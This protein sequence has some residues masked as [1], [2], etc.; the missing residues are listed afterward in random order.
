MGE[1]FAI[2]FDIAVVLILIISAFVGFRRG[3][4]RVV[5]GLVSTAL[6]FGVALLLS[7]PI[8]DGI[9]G[10]FV[11]KPIEEQFDNQT[12]A[13]LGSLDLGNIVNM[14][15][16]KVVINGTSVGD[17]EV[18]YAGTRKTVID[19]SKLDLSQTGLTS[20][21]LLKIGITED[22]LSNLNAKTAD[23]TM[24]DITN[25]GLGKLA[26]AQYLAVNLVS[27]PMFSGFDSIIDTVNSYF[28]NIFGTSRNGNA[29]VTAIRAITLQM[30]EMKEG[31]KAAVM[32]GVIKP[33]C[34]LLIRTIVFGVLFVLVSALLG[35][36]M[37]AAKLINKIPVV[38]EANAF[39][40]LVLGLIEGMIVVFLMCVATRLVINLAGANTMVFNQ[41]TIDA[42]SLFKKLYDF[43]FLNF[44]S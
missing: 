14:D 15:F 24:D 7:G 20:N 12:D 16:D 39:L 21:D 42:T 22:D 18:D 38:G 36:L 41:T 4:T 10:G 30:I 29:A 32:N 25:H 40:G 17:F 34:T 27:K 19:L 3:F 13:M 33:N 43:D 23:F 8:A 9:Y 5:L 2:A 28:P 31:F 35:V 26:V 44:L 37:S 6:A 11:A 1:Q